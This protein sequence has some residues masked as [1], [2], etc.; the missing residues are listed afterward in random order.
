MGTDEHGP[1]YPEPRKEY[2]CPI[3]NGDKNRFM[4]CEYPDCPDGCDQR[5]FKTY[6]MSEYKETP[7]PPLWQRLV[8]VAIVLGLLLWMFMTPAPAMDHGFN[9]NSA[10]TKWFERLIRPDQPPNSCCGKGDAYPVARYEHHP[11]THTWSVWLSDGSAIKYPD[12]TTRD[13]FDMSTEIIVPENKVN[14]LED[15]LDNP[16]DTSWVFMRVSTPTDVGTMYCF[17]RHPEGN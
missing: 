6:P 13:Y 8:G 16:T 2:R 10:T 7:E 15:D 4:T 11:E 12:G 9:P 1:A 14:S 5:R 17:I 3:C